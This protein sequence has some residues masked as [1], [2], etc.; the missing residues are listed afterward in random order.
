MFSTSPLLYF[1]STAE[2]SGSRR[3]RL[4][5][6]LKLASQAASVSELLAIVLASVLCSMCDSIYCSYCTGALLTPCGCRCKGR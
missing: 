4:Q 5:L 3:C 6:K 2:L 1:N